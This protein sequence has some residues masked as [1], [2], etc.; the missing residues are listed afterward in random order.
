[1]LPVALLAYEMFLGERKWKRVIPYF[2]IS[3]SFGIQALWQNRNI[4]DTNTYAIHLTPDVLW[5]S[6]AFYS[7]AIL[8]LPFAGLA[9]LLLP[10]FVR[11]RRLYVGII[12]MASA[13]IPLLVL[14]SVCL[15]YI[16][17]FR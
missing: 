9:L 11:D 4:P 8:F 1:M 17:M 3:L 6:V 16:G 2:V 10:I 15:P 7:S 14:R 13:F 5:N 12:L